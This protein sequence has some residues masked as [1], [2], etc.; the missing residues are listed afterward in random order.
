MDI[1]K[2]LDA[3][4]NC[5]KIHLMSHWVEQIRRYGASQHHAAERLEQT[6]IT[7]LKDAL[8]ASNLNLNYLQQVITF[9]C[10]ILC[11]RPRELNLQA[12]A[13]RRQNSATAYN[14]LHSC[15]DLVAP[16][17]LQVIFEEQIHGAPKPPEWK[18]SWRY[19]QS[20]QSITRQYTRRNALCGHIHRHAGVWQAQES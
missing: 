16:R 8:N 19:D 3:K 20:L 10:H 5:P 17:G 14:V 18:P 2:K 7:N 11:I 13:Q 12:L 1:S 6:H 9:Q 15:A 4:F